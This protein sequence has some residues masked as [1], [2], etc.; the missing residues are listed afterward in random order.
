[1]R[2]SSRNGST[3]SKGFTRWNGLAHFL[4]DSRIEIDNNIFERTIRPFALSRKNV[5]FAGSDDGRDNGAIIACLI[6]TAKLN[7]FD[8]EAWLTIPSS[9][10][11]RASQQATQR[12]CDVELCRRRAEKISLT[13]CLRGLNGQQAR[14]SI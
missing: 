5:L 1:M 9:N 3:Y 6:D 14:Q 10:S 13:Y 7:D 2:N 8:P 11:Q 4:D 12:T